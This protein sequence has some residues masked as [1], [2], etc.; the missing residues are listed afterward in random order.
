MVAVG[1]SWGVQGLCDGAGRHGAA[2]ASL[3][4]LLPQAW[5]ILRPSSLWSADRDTGCHI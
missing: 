4:P 1:L 2:S 5:P 3:I